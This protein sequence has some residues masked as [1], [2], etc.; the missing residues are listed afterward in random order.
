[1]GRVLPSACLG[2]LEL[3]RAVVNPHPADARLRERPIDE[4]EP[5]I[6]AVGKVSAAGMGLMYDL[7]IRGARCV[8]PKSGRDGLATVAMREG[9]C[10]ALGDVDGPAAKTINAPDTVLLPGLIDLHAHPARSGSVF[11][12]DPD[13]YMLRSGVTTV[14]S[15]GDAGAANWRCFLCETII[16]KCRRLACWLP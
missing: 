10:I 9:H 15:Q 13:T 3:R 8:C 5:R 6:A 4:A 2:D 12:V 16:I 7:L 1:L 11:G 14:L